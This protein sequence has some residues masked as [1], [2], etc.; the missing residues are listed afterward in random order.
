MTCILA[1]EDEFHIR[2]NLQQI[3]ELGGYEA[4]VA[5]DG[6]EGLEMALKYHPG[7]IISDIMMPRLDGYGLLEALRQ[8]SRFAHTPVILLTAKADR[9]DQRKG[10]ELGA[11]DYLTKPFTPPE[12]LAAVEARLQKQAGQQAVQE[13]QLNEF[14][15]NLSRSLP[16][17]LNTP[18]NSIMSFTRLLLDTPEHWNP[19]E[20]EDMLN[21]VYTSAERLHRTL[22]NFLLYADLEV[23][24]SQGP[25]SWQ[26]GSLALP[27][28]ALQGVAEMRVQAHDRIEDLSIDLP[29]VLL[30]MPQ[31]YGQKIVEELV[32]NAAKFSTPGTPV[33]VWGEVEN[34][35]LWLRVQDWGRGLSPE[36]IQQVG[37]YVQFDRRI[38]EQQGSGLGLAIVQRIVQLL[39]GSIK[40]QSPPPAPG[41]SP[42]AETD[43]ASTTVTVQ[44]SCYTEPDAAPLEESP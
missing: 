29:D 10:M 37:A 17:E 16:H 41:S 24:M 42:N 4:L 12:L 30:W 13:Q 9:P 43:P 11:D 28:L 25:S 36:H 23:K 39:G 15:D 31:Y 19:E 35:Q 5:Q 7:L 40:I 1:V 27:L 44:L 26:R 33:R 2:L 22:Q 32:D 20:T 38:Y 21:C 8:N 34:D 6:Q 18:L 14:R 3:L